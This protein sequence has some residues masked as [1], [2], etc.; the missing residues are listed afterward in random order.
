MEIDLFQLIVFFSLPISLIVIGIV[1]IHVSSLIHIPVRNML[2]L[3]GVREENGVR[4][5]SGFE[6]IEYVN[7][8]FSEWACSLYRR[9]PKHFNYVVWLTRILGTSIGIVGAEMILFPIYEPF[10]IFFAL[11]IIVLLVSEIKPID[12]E[13]ETQLRN[14]HQQ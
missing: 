11:F 5:M 6:S 3:D 8:I 9:K 7:N 12:D 2:Y 14:W 13:V 1:M 10:G 4:G